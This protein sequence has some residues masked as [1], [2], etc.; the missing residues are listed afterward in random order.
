MLRLNL[1]KSEYLNNNVPDFRDVSAIPALLQM[2]ALMSCF[3]QSSL[4]QSKVMEINQNIIA[5]LLAYT[6]PALKQGEETEEEL[7]KS[8]WTALISETLK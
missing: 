2:H 1:C 3:P 4:N 7:N 5:T 8:A 6:V